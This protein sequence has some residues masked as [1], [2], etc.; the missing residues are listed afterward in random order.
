VLVLDDVTP[1]I[2]AQRVAAWR[3]VARR[4][5]HEI[6]NPLTPIQL[7]AERLRRHFA[8]APAPAQALVHECT[9]AIIV[10][11]EALKG[12]VDEFAQFARLRGPRM[13][14]VDFNHLVDDTLRLYAG[15]LQQGAVT[16]ERDLAP[17]LPPVRADAEQIRQVIIN[18]VDNALEALGGPAAAGHDVAAPTIRVTTTYDQ[19]NGVVRL[20]V[21]DNGPGVPAADREKLFMPY[22]STKGRGSGLGL[23]IV[24][25]ILVEHGGG[26]EADEAQPSGT[27]FTV[28]LPAA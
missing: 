8:R 13:L 15:V 4:L 14:P 17:L 25:R 27:R 20:V 23:A 2:R 16:L 12:L 21:A 1:L 22:Y 10:E 6:K 28:E 19:R 24:R 9:D 5:A 7:S 3:D 26:I 18:L 11:V